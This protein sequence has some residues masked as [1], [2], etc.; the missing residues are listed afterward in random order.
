MIFI[1]LDGKRYPFSEGDELEIL[2][3]DKDIKDIY[4]NNKKIIDKNGNK[5]CEGSLQYKD[6][7]YFIVDIEEHERKID[8]YILIGLVSSDIVK[9]FHFGSIFNKYGFEHVPI[10]S[11]NDLYDYGIH[12][13]LDMLIILFDDMKNMK[14]INIDIPFFIITENK[15]DETVSKQKEFNTILYDIDHPEKM[16]DL[17]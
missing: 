16:R 1:T 6:A 10:I 12:Q 5:I 17:H 11:I 3:G 14:D 8:E 13:D 4:G 9:E 2:L 7:E 15:E